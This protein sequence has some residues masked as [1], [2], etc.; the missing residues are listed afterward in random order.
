MQDLD[1]WL[2]HDKNILCITE[3][4]YA[5]EFPYTPVK[6]ARNITHCTERHREWL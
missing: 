2:T 6:V 1:R 3:H 5:Y 4:L